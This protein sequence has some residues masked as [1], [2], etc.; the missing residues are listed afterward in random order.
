MRPTITY[1]NYWQQD[2]QC[3]QIY[4]CMANCMR[5]KRIPSAAAISALPRCTITF[6]C[7]KMSVPSLTTNSVCNSNPAP[8]AILNP[9]TILWYTND[10]T[11]HCLYYWYYYNYYYGNLQIVSTVPWVSQTWKSF[12][13]WTGLALQGLALQQQQQQQQQMVVQKTVSHNNTIASSV[14]SVLLHEKQS[15]SWTTGRRWSPFP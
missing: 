3:R 7:F 1:A 8:P 13:R 15:P 6:N 4:Q 2:T 10:V 9:H 5:I 11:R 12:L 14:K